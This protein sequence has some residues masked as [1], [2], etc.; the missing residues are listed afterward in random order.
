MTWHRDVRRL[1]RDLSG[2]FGLESYEME[3]LGAAL[4]CADLG[5][6]AAQRPRG[7]IASC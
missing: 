6:L 4:P 3:E 7:H 5:L 1:D 2:R